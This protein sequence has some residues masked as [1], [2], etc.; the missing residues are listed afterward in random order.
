VPPVSAAQRR[1]FRWA[2]ENPKAAAKRGIKQSVAQEFNAADEGGKLPE[3]V[4]KPE[5]RRYR[6]MK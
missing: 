3:R 2:A 5:S 1:L 4:E 6:K